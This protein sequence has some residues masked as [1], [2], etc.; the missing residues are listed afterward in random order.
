MVRTAPVLALIAVAA[1]ASPQ[2]TGLA[3]AM[4][5]QQRLE[6]AVPVAVRPF[7][8]NEVRLLPSLFRTQM[9][10]NGEY[11]LTLDPKRLL[12][13]FY[14]NAGLEPLA[15]IYGGWERDSISGHSFGHWLS[16]L[17]L[18]YAAT[19]DERYKTKALEAVAF[20]KRA[21]DAR[22]DGFLGGY[23]DADKLHEELRRGEINSKGFDLNGLWVPWYNQHKLFEGLI[24]VYH[25]CDDQDA[26]T[27]AAKLGDFSVWVTE[28]LTEAQWQ[29]MLDCEFGGINESLADLA[30]VTGETKYLHLAKKFDHR[31]ITDPLATHQPRLANVHGN[32][33][34]PK[35]ISAARI[36]EL[37]GDD[38]QKNIATYFWDQVVEDH[39]YANGGNTSGEYFGPPRILSRRLSDSTSETCNTYNMLKLSEHLYAWTAD[40]KYADYYERAMW[41]HILGSQNATAGKTYYV[42]LRI[43]GRKT[44]STRETHFTC[45]HGSGMESQAKYGT[46][47]F[48]HQGDRLLINQFVPSELDWTEKQAKFRLET[49]I[50]NKGT[51]TLT[52]LEAGKGDHDVQVRWPSWSNEV[53]IDGQRRL[54]SDDEQY[55]IVAPQDGWKTGASVTFEFKMGFRQEPLPDNPERVALF[56]GPALLAGDLSVLAQHGEVKPL[57]VLITDDKPFEQWLKPVGDATFQTQGVGRPQEFTLKPFFAIDR[58]Y[59]TVYWDIFTAEQWARR[60]AEYRAEEELRREL[61]ART[62]DYFA[63]GNMQSERDHNVQGEN[64]SAGTFGDRGYRHATNGGWFSFDVKVDPTIDN[65]LL[66]TFWGTDGG[67]R[68]FDVLIDGVKIREIVLERNKPDQFYDETVE[69]PVSAIEGKSKITI[70]LQARPNTTAGGL[71]GARTVRITP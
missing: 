63:P 42:P 6:T 25:Y 11:L 3:K 49:D 4:Q 54:Q 10:R 37:T 47:I 21:Q 24:D 23:P 13:R 7:A 60:E 55:F 19:G 2:S 22:P 5:T 57:P 45:C 43:G 26:L 48:A 1:A 56:Y 12:H 35:A 8:L 58:E 15:D 20:A 62:V 14:I 68:T 32:T 16:G 40:P 39:T 30:S 53:T 70:R 33:Q 66:L 71:F 46:A 65:R 41:N 38:R 18:T 61:E 31:R 17:A 51:V 28:N 50:P 67:N 27:I 44:Y 36:Y 34:I 64:T 52:L 29:Q 69:L 59:Y 9:E